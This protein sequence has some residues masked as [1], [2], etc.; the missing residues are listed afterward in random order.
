MRA[1][2]L[3]LV[4]A[5]SGGASV[6]RAQDA[7]KVQ[8]ESREAAAQ[9]IRDAFEKKDVAAFRARCSERF[10]KLVPLPLEELFARAVESMQTTGLPPSD[11]SARDDVCQPSIC[12]LPPASSTTADT[13]S[14]AEVPR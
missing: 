14:V 9:A 7:P 6:A 5:V 8:A 13:E 10:L 3:A 12:F 1:L 2:T 11:E 4:L